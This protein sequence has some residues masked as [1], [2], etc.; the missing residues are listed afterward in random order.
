M[1]MIAWI[2][3]CLFGSVGIVQCAAWLFAAWKTPPRLWRG[4]YVVPLWGG[5]EKLEGQVRQAVAQI[6]WN[7][8][9]CEPVIL[10]DSAMDEESQEICRAL[11][12]DFD[13]V[14]VC[15]RGELPD[16][17][18]RPGVLPFPVEKHT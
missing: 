2:L 9:G 17:L 8:A 10:V 15:T 3:L 14:V 5:C 7:G 13:G 6:R 4:F 12:A 11:L 1:D 16:I 18:N